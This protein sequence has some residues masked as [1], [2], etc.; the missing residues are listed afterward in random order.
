VPAR[1]GTLASL[2]EDTSLLGAFDAVGLFSVLEHLLDPEQALHQARTLL[3][4]GGV[5]ALRLPETPP[6]G[7]PASLLVH[8]YHFNKD[9]IAA[10]LR[11]G[12]FEVLYA[13]TAGIWRPTRY[14]GELPN[15]NVL[16]RTPA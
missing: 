16:S 12:G 11:R 13:Q 7:A 3:R 15:M 14:P 10:L 1:H 5:L 2:A 6:E 4:P 8:V 9:T